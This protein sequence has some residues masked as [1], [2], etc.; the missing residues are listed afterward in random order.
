M[1]IC[2]VLLYLRSLSKNCLVFVFP[3]ST[4]SWTG[5]NWKSYSVLQRQGKC[6]VSGQ[7]WGVSILLAPWAAC[8][9][10]WGSFHWE[11]EVSFLHQCHEWCE[12]ECIY[13]H[14]LFPLS[15]VQFSCSLL[16]DS[17]RPHEPQYARPSCP[18]PTPRVHPNLC[19][20]CRWCHPTISSS[21][22]PFSSF[23][24][25]FPQSGS[26]QMSQHCIRWPKFWSFSFNISPSNE[27]PGLISFRMDWLDLLVVQY[28][29]SRVLQFNIW[30]QE[31]L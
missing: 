31:S 5:K 15:S 21:V 17:L 4:V 29:D 16:S 30:T 23:P 24:Q 18:S 6:Q 28:M 11:N 27:H 25:P 2:R 13:V 20:L 22:I 19:P 14:C 3:E 8:R 10:W 26:F 9:P 1:K 7:T 12:D